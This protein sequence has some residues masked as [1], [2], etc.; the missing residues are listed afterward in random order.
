MKLYPGDVCAHPYIRGLVYVANLLINNG[1]YKVFLVLF[2]KKMILLSEIADFNSLKIDNLK[3]IQKMENVTN[4]FNLL[5]LDESGSMY[6]MKHAAVSGINEIIQTMKNMEKAYPEQKHFFTLL[7]FNSNGFVF[8][9]N[10][11][12]VSDIKEY[13]DE[14][15]QPD[16]L[17]PL[18]DAIGKGM[19]E[20][21]R[22]VGKE[23]H[24]VVNIITDG[25]EN[26]SK[27][28]GS[29]TIKNIIESKKAMGWQ[30]AYIGENQDAKAVADGMHIDDSCDF[31]ATPNGINNM[32][33]KRRQIYVNYSKELNEKI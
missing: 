17:T 14:D 2:T 32:M 27:E 4:V 29:S 23:D 12:R 30:I 33:L 26:D 19:N 1:L 16:A 11:V 18:Y 10:N 28:Y 13:G 25:L 8:R 24:V 6:S 9:Y 5:I 21:S 3:N 7:T 22:N 15:F 31:D 20:L